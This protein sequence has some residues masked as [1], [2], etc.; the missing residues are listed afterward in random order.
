MN[1]IETKSKTGFFR[2]E[3]RQNNKMVKIQSYNQT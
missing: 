1:K 3:Q 2:N